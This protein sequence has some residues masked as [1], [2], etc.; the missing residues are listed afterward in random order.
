MIDFDVFQEDMRTGE[1]VKIGEVFIPDYFIS[2]MV[3]KL[4]VVDGTEYKINQICLPIYGKN[5]IY[6]GVFDIVSR[7]KLYVE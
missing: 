2:S 4:I 1:A 5:S 6:K 7:T 3:G